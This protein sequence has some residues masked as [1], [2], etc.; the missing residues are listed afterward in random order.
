MRII[1]HNNAP[2]VRYSILHGEWVIISPLRSKRPHLTAREAKTKR[3]KYSKGCPF[4]RG[5]E[6]L[7][8]LEVMRVPENNWKVRIVRNIYPAIQS[9]DRRTLSYGFHEVVVETPYHNVQISD[10]REEE[11]TLYLQTIKERFNQISKEKGIS[12]ISIFKN[13][14]LEAGSSQEHS[15]SQIIAT[16]F[17]PEFTKRKIKRSDTYLKREGTELIGAILKGEKKERRRIVFSGTHFVVVEPYASLVPYHT[18]FIPERSVYHFGDIKED[19]VREL[20]NLVIKVTKWLKDTLNDPPYN[21]I[22]HSS[23]INRKAYRWHL[24]LIPRITAIGGFEMGTLTYINTISPEKCAEDMR[25]QI[26]F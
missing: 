5:N 13:Y 22:F 11:V 2:E 6:K 12:F 20:A 8:P 14:R 7:S 26:G 10:M 25:T 19:E 4:C 3:T 15:H 16:R 18:I 1:T 23:P 21:L 24:E 9:E 17:I